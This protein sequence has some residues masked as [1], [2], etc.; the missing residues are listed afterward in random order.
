MSTVVIRIDGT[1]VTDDVIIRGASFTSLVNGVTG[2]AVLR[3]KDVG[4]TY[5][6]ISGGSLTLDVD[7]VRV[8]G[9]YILSAKK[10]YALEVVD[11]VT[12]PIPR[13]WEIVGGDYN[14]LFNK[15][16]VFKESD[17]TGKI[18]FSYSVD[19]YDDTI[20]DDIFDNYLDISG[21]SLTRTGVQRIAKATLDIPGQSS[22]GLIASAGMTWKQTMDRIQRATGGVYYIDASRDLKYVDVETS[23]SSYTL[24][25]Q[26]SGAFD[27]GYQSFNILRNGS[28]LV[29]D[30]F[31]W[32]AGDGSSS[33]VF[34]RT[35]D[36]SSIAEHGRW[37][38]P[39]VTGGLFRQASADIIADSYVYGTPQSHRGGK[40]EAITF[41]AR[42]FE[43]KFAAGDVVDVVNGIF[44][45]SDALPVRRMTTT[46]QSPTDPIFDILLSHAIDQ[47]VSL[48]EWMIPRIP[49]LDP[50][51]IDIWVPPIPPIDSTTCPTGCL[52]ASCAYD[53]FVRT[54][55]APD[56][57]GD[58][59]T[60]S[61]NA[62]GGGLTGGV[63]NMADVAFTSQTR[64]TTITYNEA[65]TRALA[66][67]CDTTPG[68]WDYYAAWT[69]DTHFDSYAVTSTEGTPTPGSVFF[70]GAV[71][72]FD[73][74]TLTTVPQQFIQFWFTTGL[75]G[76]SVSN[77]SLLRIAM[78][79]G[80]AKWSLGNVGL[81]TS[82]QTPA[83][84]SFVP[85][86]TYKVHVQLRADGSV[87]ANLWDAAI[88]EPAGWMMSRTATSGTES[89]NRPVSFSAAFVRGLQAGSLATNPVDNTFDFDAVQVDLVCGDF[90]GST[91]PAHVSTEYYA[92]RLVNE[93]YRVDS[94][95]GPAGT[96]N[97]PGSV[98]ADTP[99]RIR[100]FLTHTAPAGA[101]FARLTTR[102]WSYQLS[103]TPGSIVWN[104][105]S[106]GTWGT[107][108]VDPATFND[109]DALLATGTQT[110]GSAVQNTPW[111]AAELDDVSVD[112]PVVSGK[113]KFVFDVASSPGTGSAI[114]YPATN[115]DITNHT[116]TQY[117]ELEWLAN[118]PLNDAC[119]PNAEIPAP[120]TG[121]EGGYCETIS[122]TGG[123][124]FATQQAFFSGSLEVWVNGTRQTS[125]TFTALLGQFTLSAALVSTDVLRVCYKA[126]GDPI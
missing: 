112:V 23:T 74:G 40:D 94:I 59:T 84:F 14:T 109:V 115:Y 82:F 51:G 38:L 77:P 32:G 60:T 13:V 89:Q 85:G 119:F 31:V 17:P 76:G 7:S 73:I 101:D 81:S 114:M 6:F 105:Y 116:L 27:V 29:N 110:V 118:N 103:P 111:S 12:L 75:R 123:T 65:G 47:P 100:V 96:T 99:E 8:W 124:T 87:R 49:W 19:T 48:F 90:V 56:W 68:P 41:T 20:I 45:Y 126:N 70:P 93:S 3:V 39:L 98:W 16:I 37:Q 10:V 78:D 11:T 104:V 24:T 62:A 72:E 107:T 18:N 117:Y 28:D 120:T 61:S 22:A 43:P 52:L 54:V 95:S 106:G 57:G 86:N 46:F 5:D 36:S 53:D 35:E 58:W 91:A 79:S 15:R 55:S 83:T 67:D 80:A 9:G 2:Q 102:L 26:P 44:S 122:H 33:Y 125:F 34:S 97:M 1:D 30:M 50:G 64:S 66:L 63:A 92:D 121:P 71:H 69:A 42:L 25:D 21:D 108:G 113:A 88:D 4:Q